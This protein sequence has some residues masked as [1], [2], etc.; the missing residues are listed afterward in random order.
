MTRCVVR[1]RGK[2][3][4]ELLERACGVYLRDRTVQKVIYEVQNNLQQSGHNQ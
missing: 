2:L 3:N 1:T 4:V